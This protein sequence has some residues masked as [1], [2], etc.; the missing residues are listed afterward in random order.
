MK[1]RIKNHSPKI[2]GLITGHKL[3]PRSRGKNAPQEFDL[4]EAQ[5]AN[6]MACKQFK[7]WQ[8]LGWCALVAEPAAPKAASEPPAEEKLAGLGTR[9]AKDAVREETDTALLET[10]RDGET[11]RTVQKVIKERLEEL[12]DDRA[13]MFVEEGDE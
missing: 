1:V 4:T 5:H 9:A 2:L 11:R 13:P 6:L 10:W 12:A 8:K 3:M 7:A